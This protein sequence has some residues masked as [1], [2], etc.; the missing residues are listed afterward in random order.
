MDADG[1]NA[2]ES[3]DASRI[4]FEDVVGILARLPEADP[5][6]TINPATT[7]AGT[8]TP[9]Q[10]CGIE[11]TDNTQG[12]ISVSFEA[13]PKDQRKNVRAQFK[14]N[15][16]A[17]VLSSKPVAAA[18]NNAPS[19]EAALGA[20]KQ[21]VIA[22]GANPSSRYNPGATNRNAR[23]AWLSYHILQLSERK[24]L[25]DMN[26]EEAKKVMATD[27]EKFKARIDKLVTLRVQE[28]MQELK[29]KLK[30]KYKARYAGKK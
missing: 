13:N 23:R 2:S 21:K 29:T 15:I 12:T 26:D 6:A 10:E 11:A 5:D 4:D 8:E 14:E 25:V 9:T 16:M 17:R 24:R 1:K 7:T 22:L 3:L 19:T 18:C 20:L 27:A 28:A 30:A